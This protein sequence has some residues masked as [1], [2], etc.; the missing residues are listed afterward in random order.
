M[1]RKYTKVNPYEKQILS[2]KREGKTQEQAYEIRRLR[3]ENE[4]LRDFMRSMGRRQSC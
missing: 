3:M 4:L 1:P 2:M